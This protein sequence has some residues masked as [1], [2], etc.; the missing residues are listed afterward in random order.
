MYTIAVSPAF[1]EDRTLFVGTSSIGPQNMAGL[2]KSTNGGFNWRFIGGNLPEGLSV[3][4]IILSPDYLE[5][6]NQRT[7]YIVAKSDISQTPLRI[8]RSVN[9]G[10]TWTP[11]EP[12]WPSPETTDVWD[13]SLSPHHSFD[14][15][16]LVATSL[17]MYRTT[18]RGA[19]WEEVNQGITGVYVSALAGSNTHVYARTWVPTNLSATLSDGIYRLAPT[20]DGWLPMEA[21]G[22]PPAN[23]SPTTPR[24]MFPPDLAVLPDDSVLF[25]WGLENQ[26]VYRSWDGGDSWEP[27]NN[28]MT[29]PGRSDPPTVRMLHITPREPYTMYAVADVGVFWSANQGD[30]WSRMTLPVPLPVVALTTGGTNYRYVF[31]LYQNGLLFRS[32]DNGLTWENISTRVP[33]Y[34]LPWEYLKSYILVAHPLHPERIYLGGGFPLTSKA[35]CN[36]FYFSSDG[37]DHWV[38]LSTR[39]PSRNVIIDRLYISPYTPDTLWL[40][41]RQK[42]GDF[43]ADQVIAQGLFAST[44]QGFSWHE[45]RLDPRVVHGGIR[46]MYIDETGRMYFATAGRSIWTGDEAEAHTVYIPFLNTYESAK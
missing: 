2:F 33:P 7:L 46:D 6:S 16:F 9:G 12:E 1:A 37:G 22:F 19:T 40:L 14:H 36:R 5:T 41:V 23:V 20:G 43:P 31:V 21:R 28:G 45:V 11:V 44:D 24:A 32:W 10:A 26:G 30:T 3:L 39:V 4:K 34:P 15:T 25:A 27:A 35:Q 38:N 18:D 29:L 8:Y 42:Q 13:L 17:G